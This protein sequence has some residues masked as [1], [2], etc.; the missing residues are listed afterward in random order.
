LLVTDPQAL[1]V[2]E[3]EGE[4]VGSV[5]A[6]WNGWRGSLY[7]LAVDP[8]HRRAGVATRLVRHAEHRLMELGAVRIDAVVDEGDVAA[9]RFWA[10]VGYRPHQHRSRFKR[11]L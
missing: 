5:I 1:L 8:D 11:D 9:T 4:L 2:A 3:I 10:S 6:G 7:R